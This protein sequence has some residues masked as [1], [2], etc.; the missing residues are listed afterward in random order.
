MDTESRYGSASPAG[1]WR[2]VCALPLQN[3]FHVTL[4]Q[5]ALGSAAMG[6]C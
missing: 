2:Q 1:E 4:D 6:T 3:A 5:G